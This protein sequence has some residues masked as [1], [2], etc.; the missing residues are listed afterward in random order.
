LLKQLKIKLRLKKQKRHYHDSSSQSLKKT[1]VKKVQKRI[2]DKKARGH[3]IQLI[4]H[5]SSS[6]SS[7][8]IITFQK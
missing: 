7:K 4:R 5:P 1:K 3:H 8:E 2:Q 6:S